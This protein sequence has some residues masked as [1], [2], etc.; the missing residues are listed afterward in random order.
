MMMS[1]YDELFGERV[2]ARVRD[3]GVQI[4]LDEEVIAYS[5]ENGAV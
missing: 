1:H 4:H 3:V 2:E 5:G